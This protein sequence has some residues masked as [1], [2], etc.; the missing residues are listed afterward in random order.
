MKNATLS[1]RNQNYDFQ[2]K[3]SG[4]QDVYVYNM[5][6]VTVKMNTLNTIN[7]VILNQN[8]INTMGISILNQNI[9]TMMNKM[10]IL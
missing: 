5:N 8:M 4:S 3:K 7:I 1:F 2:N 9:V 6:K 10:I